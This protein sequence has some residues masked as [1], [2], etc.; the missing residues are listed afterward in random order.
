[1]WIG[2][3]TLVLCQA[4]AIDGFLPF[5]AASND[6]K[7]CVFW[8]LYCFW[9]VSEISRLLN[10]TLFYCPS[11]VLKGI[12]ITHRSIALFWKLNGRRF[13]GGFVSSMYPVSSELGSYACCRSTRASF[14]SIR[15]HGCRTSKLGGACG[16]NALVCFVVFGFFCVMDL[17]K[18]QASGEPNN[19][20]EIPVLEGSS[21]SKTHLQKGNRTI[22]CFFPCPK[23]QV[24][25]A[26][27]ICQ[28]V[29]DAS[30]FWRGVVRYGV[31]RYP[32]V[33]TLR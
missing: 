19:C 21:Q 14:I 8:S 7:K 26:L 28:N 9:S 32:K 23:S 25:V 10:L 33:K 31:K 29:R 6:L 4:R 1:M 13:V 24:R 11:L 12:G 2:L 3:F 20:T 17:V 5:P 15:E 18:G 22:S 16:W 27:E 30:R